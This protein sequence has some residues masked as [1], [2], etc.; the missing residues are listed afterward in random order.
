MPSDL[1]FAVI[2]HAVRV[3]AFVDSYVCVLYRLRYCFREGKMD[4]KESYLPVALK[5]A[6]L[7]K[8]KACRSPHSR[9]SCL[10][11]ALTSCVIIVF[12]TFFA[13]SP[14]S[15]R[16]ISIRVKL[17]VFPFFPFLPML[18]PFF[19]PY[20]SLFLLLF[21]LLLFLMMVLAASK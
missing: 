10:A 5:C 13:N 16:L 17:F 21:L 19:N 11:G 2:A 7:S 9:R 15:R 20:F 3:Y 6:A 12:I 18:T 8:G 1:R 14:H 4:G